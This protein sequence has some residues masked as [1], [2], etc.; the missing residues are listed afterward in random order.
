MTGRGAD[1]RIGPGLEIPADELGFETTRSGGPGG[2]NVN[3][4]E[5]RVTLRFDVRGSRVLTE[6][7]R[8]CLEQ[9]LCGRMNRAGELVV[10]SSRY[11]SQARNLEDARERT[12]D[13]IRAALAPRRRRRKTR[14]TRASK[15]RRLTQKRRR[16]DTKRDRRGPD[17]A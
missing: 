11:R 3:K 10:H 7:Q 16:G 5:T 4:V 8:A 14:P 12:A 17:D 2:Q 9:R 15:E 13:L 1:L 6:E